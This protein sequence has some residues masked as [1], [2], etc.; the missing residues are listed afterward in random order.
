WRELISCKET[1]ADLYDVTVPKL[2]SFIGGGFI[3]HN[4]WA[5]LHK[6]VRHLWDTD[7]AR[8][9]MFSKTMKKSKEGGTWSDINR[10]TLPE[11]IASGIG[12]R[13]T[14]KTNEGTP[15]PKIDG[16]TR[17]PYFRITNRHGTTS[18]AMLFSL[19]YDKDVEDKLK[20]MRFS[21]IYFSEL[22]KFRERMV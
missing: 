2:H 22:S 17:T 16:Q 4:T 8:L 15:G 10:I 13:Y 19:D 3:N 21:C 11:W 5:V 9:A 7:G 20:E 1:A 18:E 12:L 6:L 14:T